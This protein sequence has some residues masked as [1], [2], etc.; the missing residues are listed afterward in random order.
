MPPF[1]IFHLLKCHFFSISSPKFI[2][3]LP[4]NPSSSWK[5]AQFLIPKFQFVHSLSSN[6][7]PNPNP[8]PNFSESDFNTLCNV[9]KKPSA[10]LENALHEVKFEP[11]TSLLLEIF[12]KFDAAPNLVFILFKWSEKQSGY[13]H[14]MV[15]SD[16]LDRKMYLKPDWAPSIDVYNML[17]EG[18]FRVQNTKQV[19]RLWL[20]MRA[21]KLVPGI[22]T[23]GILVEGYCKMGLV[24]V[25]LE[26]LGEMRSDGVVPN[27]MVY[28]HMVD[29]LA[30]SGRLKEALRMLER[31]L[32][33]EP[34]PTLRT[35]NSLIRGFCKAGDLNGAGKILRMMI[36]RGVVPTAMTYNWFFRYYSKHGEVEEGV[37][38]YRKMVESGYEP[39]V[40]TFHLMLKMLCEEER[41]ELAMQIRKDMRSRDLVLDSDI[42]TMLIDL[43]CRMHKLE[44]A[45]VEFEELIQRGC[46]P[47]YISYETLHC[48]LKKKGL[49]EMALKITELVA[50]LRSST[51]LPNEYGAVDTFHERRKSII[52]RAKAMSNTLKTCS[53]SGEIGNR[54]RSSMRFPVG[55]RTKV[56]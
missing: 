26:L 23:Y 42:N 16:Y 50:T 22:V 8:N 55:Q 53:S 31:F 28:G 43:L 12:K 33:V 17:L 20:R 5:Q 7:N 46:V 47:R 40:L 32:V 49:H 41:L 9:L 37:N 48:E 18:W 1:F 54:R 10:D 2:Q 25:A 3:R 44:D 15:A 4:L 19:E 38:L 36:S 11:S 6:I 29:A 21:G 51:S 56:K 35:Y 13:G 39:D 24:D 52:Q 27:R 34:G 14:V 45:V 30:G